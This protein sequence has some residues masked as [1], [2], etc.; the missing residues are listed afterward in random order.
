MPGRQCWEK[1]LT[2]PIYAY[3]TFAASLTLTRSGIYLFPLHLQSLK[4]RRK[5]VE[6]LWNGNGRGKVD[7]NCAFI[8]IVIGGIFFF[9]FSWGFVICGDWNGVLKVSKAFLFH[10]EI[11]F[12]ILQRTWNLPS[13]NVK[14]LMYKRGIIQLRLH[15][16][17]NAKEVNEI[18]TRG[19][20]ILMQPT[21][22]IHWERVF[23][24]LK[25]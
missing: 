2:S 13:S 18:T 14:C 24:I 1:Y 10:G 6:P 16:S 19:C 15:L 5:I 8:I 12:I 17:I 4:E 7:P 22:T 3:F 20:V 9:E 21:P 25:Y 23:I 11:S